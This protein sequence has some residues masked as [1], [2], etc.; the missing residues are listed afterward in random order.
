MFNVVGYLSYKHW[1]LCKKSTCVGVC[2]CIIMCVYPLFIIRIILSFILY[3]S[4]QGLYKS[5]EA[6]G[7]FAAICYSLFFSEEAYGVESL[8][9]FS[10]RICLSRYIPSGKSQWLLK[11]KLCSLFGTHT[12]VGRLMHT[13]YL[14]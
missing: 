4:G 11:Q 2:V 13:N 1:T 10:R 5:N 12:F 9:D 6:G 8:I 14:K 3:T 7:S